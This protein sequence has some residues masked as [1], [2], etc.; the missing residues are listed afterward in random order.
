MKIGTLATMFLLWM[1]F[2]HGRGFS[3]VSGCNRSDHG[4]RGSVLCWRRKQW[5]RHSRRSPGFA[6]RRSAVDDQEMTSLELKILAVKTSIR[7]YLVTAHCSPA[8]P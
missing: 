6:V 1:M 5:N 4:Q 7:S 2:V 3:E 8:I